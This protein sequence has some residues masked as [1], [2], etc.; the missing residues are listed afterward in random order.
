MVDSLSAMQGWTLV[1]GLALRGVALGSHLITNN[2]AWRWMISSLVRALTCC[3]P[4]MVEMPLEA[5]FYCRAQA[6]HVVG[7]DRVEASDGS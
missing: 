5:W 4:P 1:L 6:S 3:V 7:L 2:D